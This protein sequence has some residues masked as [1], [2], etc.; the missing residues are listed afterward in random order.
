[1]AAWDDR[2]LEELWDSL[3]PKPTVAVASGEVLM[4]VALKMGDNPCELR[5]ANRNLIRLDTFYEVT[6]HGIFPMMDD[7]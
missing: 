1:M 4:A 3:K 2:T 7:L 5:D 6:A